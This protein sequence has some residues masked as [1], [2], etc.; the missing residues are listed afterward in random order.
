MTL[1]VSKPQGV[2]HPENVGLGRHSETLTLSGT[3]FAKHYPYWQQILAQIH[4]L[5]GTS[6]QQRV[7]FLAQ[8]M[9]KSL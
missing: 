4:T 1:N 5:T 7:H 8:L 3:R 6:P 9:F 2:G